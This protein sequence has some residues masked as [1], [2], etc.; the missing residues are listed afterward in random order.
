MRVFLLISLLGFAVVAGC[1]GPRA[2]AEREPS[3]PVPAQCDAACFTKC[4]TPQPVQWACN[5]SDPRCW[6]LLLVQVIAP[7]GKG[8]EQCDVQNRRACCGAVR[9]NFSLL[10][11]IASVLPSDVISF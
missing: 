6:D 2:V 9:F 8:L 4:T 3:P 7:L 1:G 10:P 11:G 5:P